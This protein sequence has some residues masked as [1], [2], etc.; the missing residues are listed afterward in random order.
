MPTKTCLLCGSPCE[1][2]A[3]LLDQVIRA[4]QERRWDREAKLGR[5]HE[6]DAQVKSG[7][8]FNWHIGRR[9]AG[10]SDHTCA[11]TC[12][13]CGRGSFT[14]DP[15]T[16]E[17]TVSRLSQVRIRCKSGFSHRPGPF[18]SP[19]QRART[20]AVPTAARRR[21]ARKPWPGRPDGPSTI[22][23]G[24]ASGS[25][26]FSAGTTSWA[27]RRPGTRDAF[28]PLLLRKNSLSRLPHSDA[29]TPAVTAT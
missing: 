25:R 4:Q 9:T 27:S 12:C 29:R 8:L 3:N 5:R 22:V 24:P 17:R 13:A 28:H 19:H 16:R 10:S 26:A 7:G 15:L 1:I 6:I 2:I 20:F 14:P 11:T 21:L 23:G 18:P